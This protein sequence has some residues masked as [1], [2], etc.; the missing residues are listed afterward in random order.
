VARGVAYGN[1]DGLLLADQY[2][3]PL[4]AR[5]GGVEQ[6]TLQHGVMLRQQR[7]DH[8]RIFRALALVDGHGVGR[9]QGV[10]LAEGVDNGTSVETGGELAVVGADIQ[11]MADV[12]VVNLLVVIVP[13]SCWQ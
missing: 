5:D 13:R 4:A 11:D 7:N 9:H 12:A 6:V 1:R 2:H 3:Q 8:R 10:Q